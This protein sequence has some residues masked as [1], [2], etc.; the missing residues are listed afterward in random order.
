MWIRYDFLESDADF[1]KIVVHGHTP[2]DAPELK[3]NRIGI[4][5]G[6]Y[7]SGVL[8]AVRLEGTDRQILQAKA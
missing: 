6:V 5:T 8:T 2:S 4:D 3:A 1:G 7:Y